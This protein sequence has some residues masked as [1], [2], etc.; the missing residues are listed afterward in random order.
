MITSENVDAILGCPP[1]RSG[2]IK[3]FNPKDFFNHSLF[4]LEGNLELMSVSHKSQKTMVTTLSGQ[5]STM[6]K[7]LKSLQHQHEE[8]IAKKNVALEHV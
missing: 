5:V 6:E 3:I 1:I 7:S 8:E 2:L 4:Q